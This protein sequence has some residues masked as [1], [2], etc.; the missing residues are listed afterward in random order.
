MLAVGIRV[1]IYLHTEQESEIWTQ[2]VTG[3]VCWQAENSS[4]ECHCQLYLDKVEKKYVALKHVFSSRLINI[5]FSLFS[6][7]WMYIQ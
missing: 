2:V 6:R 1:Q 3:D 5:V 4:M 7:L